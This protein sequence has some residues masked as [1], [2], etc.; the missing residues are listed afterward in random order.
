MTSA[1]DIIASVVGIIGGLSLAFG[2]W[3]S[4]SL[5]AR[6][7]FVTTQF[8]SGCAMGFVAAYTAISSLSSD[9][10]EWIALGAAGGAGVLFGAIIGFV[11][12]VGPL[13]LLVVTGAIVGP[14]LLLIDAHDGADVFPADNQLARQEFVIAFL[15]IFVLVCSSRSKTNEMENHRFKYV[16]FTAFVGGWMLADAVSRFVGKG[17]L[18]SVLYNSF[19]KGGSAALEDIDSSAQTLMFLVWGGVAIVGLLNQMAMRWGLVCYNRVGSHA[20]LSGPIEENLPELPTGATLVAQM[21]T[22]RVRLVCENC[23]ATVPSGTAFCTE[24]GEAMPGDDMD[25]NVSISQAQMP[26]VAMNST[27]NA[28]DRWQPIPHRAY[29]STTS[30][31]D[32]KLA[33]GDVSMKGDGRSIRFMDGGVQDPDG[34]LHGY[35]DNSMAN[36]PNFYEPSFRSFAMSTYSIANRAAEPVETPNIRKYKMSGSGI[37]HLVYFLSAIAGIWWLAFLV[38]YYPQEYICSNVAPT[39]PC[40]K[41]DASVKTG[42]YSSKKNFDT[43]SDEGYCIRDTPVAVWLM[44][45]MMVFSE[46]LNFFLGLLF[47]FSMWRPIRRGARFMNDFKPP[48]P[49]EQWPTVDVFLCHY[50]EP[51]SD[52]MQ[53]LKNCLAMQYPPELVHIWILDDGYT[54]SVWDANNHF[55]VTVNTKVIEQ[56]GDLRGDLARLMHERIVGPVQ[57]DISLK[58]WRRQHSSVRELRKEGGKGV[59]RRDC[60]VGSLSDDYDYRDRG[61]PRVTFVGRMK[62]ETHHSKAGNINNALF[63]EGAE[64]KYLLILDNDMKPH[65]KFL[66]AVL[67]FFFSEGEAVD[68]GG[69][70]YSDDISWNQVS[71]VQTPQY[72]EDTPQL[73]IMGDP[74]GHK[75]TIFFDAVQCGRDGFDSAAFAGTNAVFRR[76]AFDSIGGI[77]YGTQTE[78]AYTGNILHTSGWDSVYFRKDFEGDQKDRIRLCEGAIPETVATSMGQKK[79]WAKGA[80]QILLMKSES[81]VDP[82]WRP[83]RVP[84]PDPKPSL[85]FPRKMF[86]WDS[87]FYPFGSIPAMCY[88]VIAIYYLCT[89]DAPIYAKG[90]QFMYSFLPLMLIKWLLNLLANRAVDNNDVW[91]A[92][93]TWFSYSFVTMLAIIE[94]IQARVTGKDKSWANTGA[95]QKTSWTEI[96]NVLIFFTMGISQVVALI[97]FFQYENATNP[98]NYVSAMFFGLFIMS[99][100]YPMVKM[101]ITEYCGWDHTAATFTANIFGS[102]IMV[103]MVVFVQLW[104]VYFE[105]NLAVARGESDSSSTT[106]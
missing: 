17:T 67:P 14:Y 79:R 77:Q 26:S 55:K 15:I 51:V 18:S 86:F 44:Y 73:T 56:C 49:K 101:S 10:N 54:K 80:V 78:D 74:C 47:N 9:T 53:T 94:A 48:I 36:R 6:S 100:F 11:T 60:A 75:N 46:F 62:P 103:F 21:P 12:M 105:G 4:L 61:I 88:V 31:V 43:S 63:N 81:E 41:L 82:D 8:I 92:Q 39:L 2:G 96:P 66:L 35:N 65:P 90:T 24:C 84:A 42:C 64:G 71:Y 59:Q 50:T 1:V 57:D 68:G 76:Q 37:F 83:P 28:P 89:G 13:L 45:A 23:F 102:L 52:S 58:S 20:Q 16:I 69:R 29:V 104:Q 98:W 38:G 27:T 34:K 22:E 91:R 97:R 87:V 70:Q 95:G 7:L 93:Q 72:F 3:S 30:Y 99:N 19:Q 106:T 40:S 85:A 33:K 25:P 32:P 5:G